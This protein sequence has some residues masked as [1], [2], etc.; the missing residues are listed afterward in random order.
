MT[1]PTEA[2]AHGELPKEWDGWFRPARPGSKLATTFAASLQAPTQNMPTYHEPIAPARRRRSNCWIALP[3][4]GLLLTV[5]AY[6]GA[7]GSHPSWPLGAVWVASHRP[8]VTGPAVPG[9]PAVATPGHHHK[10]HHHHKH[11]SR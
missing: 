3:V 11:A 5:V 6:L 7:L 1:A 2:I 8:V 9:K 10:R 4:I